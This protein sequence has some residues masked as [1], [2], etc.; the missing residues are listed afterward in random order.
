MWKSDCLQLFKISYCTF[1]RFQDED[2][3]FGFDKPP[4]RGRSPAT[5][6]PEGMEWLDHMSPS[7]RSTPTKETVGKDE[8][9]PAKESQIKDAPSKEPTSALKSSTPPGAKTPSK[10]MNK[11][12]VDPFEYLGLK[13]DED[14]GFEWMKPKQPEVRPGTGEQRLAPVTPPQSKV[15]DH[16]KFEQKP[17]EVDQSPDDYLGLGGE[18]DLDSMLKYVTLFSLCLI[19]RVKSCSLKYHP[20]NS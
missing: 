10:T 9:T 13:D 17:V 11:P 8:T 7:P 1:C 12:K 4:S 14:D 2:D 16:L 15:P 5:K 19:Y 6:K 20:Y 18:V 3:I